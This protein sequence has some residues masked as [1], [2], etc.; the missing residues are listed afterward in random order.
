MTQPQVELLTTGD[1]PGY[2]A[3]V[4]SVD[5]THVS[6]TSGYRAVLRDVLDASDHYLV[7][8]R[9]GEIVGALPSFLAEGPYGNVLNSLPFFGSHGSIVVSADDP[10]ADGVIS[11]LVSGLGDLAREHDAVTATIVTGPLLPHQERLEASIAPWF[12]DERIG[13]ICRLPSADDP[14]GAAGALIEAVDPKRRWDVRKARRLGVT[15]E[16][17]F[18]AD[19]LRYLATI[20]ASGMQRLGVPAKGRR[21]FR[22]IVRHLPAG[23]EWRLFIAR[24]DGE[25]IGGLLAL[26][27]GAIAEYFVPAV[28]SEHRSTQAGSLLVFAAMERAIVDG[29][30]YWN[31]GGTATSGQEGVY[32]FKER[33]GAKDAPYRYLGI[34]FGD[35]E[36]LIDRT[37]EE[38]LTAYPSFFVVPFGSLDAA[39]RPVEARA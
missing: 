1:E 38:L 15:C 19:D 2:D 7:A 8:R 4:D 16:E 39:G 9:G 24:L 12:V 13:Q 20:H 11:T 30:R 29:F 6:H 36:W 37:P 35:T 23:S 31:L 26:Y 34:G 28:A 18:E 3:F 32:R 27:H 17:S 21:V 14:R 22:S 33:W 25:R 10:D 5:G